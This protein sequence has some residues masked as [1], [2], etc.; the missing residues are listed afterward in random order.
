MYKQEHSTF[1]N[2]FLQGL[3]SFSLQ[4]SKKE[5]RDSCHKATLPTTQKAAREEKH[6]VWQE[7]NEIFWLKIE[8]SRSSGFICN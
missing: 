7:V 2:N 5:T 6:L 8:I 3:E 1:M 4:I